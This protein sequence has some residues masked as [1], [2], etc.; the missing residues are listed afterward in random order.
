MDIV[1]IKN[2]TG[3]LILT[4]IICGIPLLLN[5][6]DF[7]AAYVDFMYVPEGMS[8]NYVSMEQDIAKP[9]HQEAVNQ[10]RL[11]SWSLWAIPFPGG[12]GA[13]YHYATVRIYENM[14]QIQSANEFGELFE[15]VHEGQNIDELLETVWN[16]RDLVKTHRL[17]SWERFGHENMTSPAGMIQV[18]Y[19][20]VP[21][22]NEE[23]Y[24]NMEI[25][26][27]H[28]MHKKEIELGKRAGWEGWVLNQPYGNSVPYNHVAVDSYVN[29]DQFV[30]EFDYEAILEEVHPGKTSDYMGDV[31]QNTAELVGIE[32]WHLI[33]FVQAE[34]Q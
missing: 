4:F 7:R 19:F 30:M 31:F 18:V 26:L 15:M 24:R 13:E 11:V 17:F 22:G 33:D 23:A 9:V 20:D 21:M 27:A 32:H 8:G 1:M 16:T 10:G 28:P 12:T 34:N 6:Q 5:G 14:E 29:M 3:V 25:D 2:K